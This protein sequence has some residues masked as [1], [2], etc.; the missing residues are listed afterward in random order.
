MENKQIDKTELRYLERLAEIYPTISKASTE[1]INLQAIL[2]LPKGTEHFLSDIHGEYEAFSHVLKNGSGTVRRKIDEIFGHTLSAKDK[3][4]LATVIYYPRE[5]MKLVKKTEPFMDEWYRITLYRLIEVCRQVASKYT[6]SKVSKAMPK[7]FSYITDELITEKPELQDKEAYYE[8]IINTIIEIGQAEEFIAALSELI[9]RLVVDHL[10]VLG[11]IYDRGPGPHLIIDKLMAYH[12]VDIQWGNHDILWM[13]AA[14]GQKTCIANV[15]RIC[16]R[17][18]NLDILEDGYGINLL[19]LATFALQT[20]QHDPCERFSIKGNRGNESS[21]EKEISR[22]M[23]KAISIIAL[24][25]EGELLMKRPC[26]G[27]DNRLLLDKIDYEK[28]T[29]TLEGKTHA[30]LDT[31]FPTIDPN[32]PYAL[33]KEEDEVVERLVSAFTGC[34]KL[35][36]HTLFLLKK[37]SLYKIY[38]GNLLYH[39]CIPLNEDGSFRKVEI[40]GEHYQGRALYDILEK[41]VR[42]AFFAMDEEEREKGKDILWYIWSG[43]GSPMFGKHKMATFERCFLAEPE[44]YIEKKNPY[45]QFLDNGQVVESI[46]DEFQV[47]GRQRHIV[48]GH[49]PV[50]HKAGESPIKCGGKL[51]IIDG[52]FAKAYQKETGIAGYTLIFNSWGMRLAAHQPFTS[53]EDAI[54]EEIDIL[55]DNIEIT[56]LTRRSSVGDTDTGKQLRRRID[57]LKELLQAYRSGLLVEKN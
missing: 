54:A 15:I 33:T 37:G 44:T 9:Q 24:K 16:A 31:N 57:E 50:H 25:L 27:M 47:E 29:I 35:Q 11:D 4:A 22:K 20:Y 8:Q 46:L 21:A 26:F 14:A 23:Y 45:Y 19:P 7:D 1:I 36:K 5:K 32:H 39:G 17:Y 55:S 13:G 40:Y 28:G 51:L 56:R 30:L 2:N 6:K 41:Y 3:K 12:S 49:V 38:N 48:N 34:E 43:P 53:A 52:G 10:H 18:S 42:K